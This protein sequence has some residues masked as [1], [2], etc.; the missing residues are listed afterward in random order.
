VNLSSSEANL[1]DDF[2]IGNFVVGLDECQKLVYAKEK[3]EEADS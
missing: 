1:E 2:K 3:V